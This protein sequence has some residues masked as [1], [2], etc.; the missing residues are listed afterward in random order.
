MSTLELEV[1]F[2]ADVGDSSIVLELG[3]MVWAE[4]WREICLGQRRWNNRRQRMSVLVEGH[5][6][7]QRREFVEAWEERG[8]M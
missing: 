1:S 2:F 5:G 6:A 8:L 4:E 7:A 3:T